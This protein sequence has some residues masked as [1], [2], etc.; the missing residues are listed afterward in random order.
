[1]NTAR[2]VLPNFADDATRLA[3]FGPPIFGFVPQAALLERGWSWF[4]RD[5][6][7]LEAQAHYWLADA[8]GDFGLRQTARG[9][10]GR[11]FRGFVFTDVPGSSGRRGDPVR[12]A[13]SLHLA[14]VVNS[15]RT[16]HYEVGSGLRPERQARRQQYIDA[17]P[18]EPAT[19]DFQRRRTPPGDTRVDS[20]S[21]VRV[22][23]AEFSAFATTK[24]GRI[25][26]LVLHRDDTRRVEVRLVR[27]L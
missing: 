15:Y 16:S 27:V 13:L 11:E 17:A 1:M 23:C 8:H 10:M 21:A 24:A 12:D 20:R 26:T 14:Q 2:N 4:G 18:G 5:G 25:V 9:M 6:A 7:H 19:I 22:T 3:E